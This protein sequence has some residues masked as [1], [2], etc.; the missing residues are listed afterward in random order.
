MTGFAAGFT[1]NILP[2][3]C[4]GSIG[5][6]GPRGRNRCDR[7]GLIVQADVGVPHRHADVAVASQLT[8]LDERCTVTQQLGDVSVPTHRVE[9]GSSLFGPV[10]DANPLEV[11]LDHQPGARSATYEVPWRKWADG[12]PGDRINPPLTYGPAFRSP[13]NPRR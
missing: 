9:V 12:K 4:V 2:G 13:T 11:L 5:L 3:F 8:G 10:R 7:P 1:P 6:R